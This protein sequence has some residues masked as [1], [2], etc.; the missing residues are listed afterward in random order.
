VRPRAGIAMCVYNGARYLRAQLD[1]FA[2]QSE[3]PHRLVVVDDGSTDG[4]WDLLQAWAARA[5]FPVTLE[6]NTQNLG[7]VRNF[8]KAVRLLLPEVDVVFFSDQD[9]QWY[10]AKLA[11]C[12]DAFVT[13]PRLGL[14]HSDAD[15]VDM[16]GRPLGSRLLAALLVTERERADVASGHAYRAY[17]RRNLVT[18]AAAA[19]RSSVLAQALPFSDQMIH[20]EWISYVAS[21][22]G[23]VRMLEEPLMA[24]RLH[25]ANTVGLPIPNRI[26]W[27]RSVFKALLEPQVPRQ[28]QRLARLQAM[29]AHAVQLGA[30]ADVFA[31]LDRA[32]AHAQHRCSL[33][34]NPLR[35]ALAVRAEWRDGQYRRWSSGRMS[36]LHDLLIAN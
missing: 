32:I 24:Y 5:P 15:L 7:V 36:M 1:S 8:E 13:D 33:S 11:T 17:I 23:P 3:L 30:D 14:V 21:V 28:Q 19:C 35:R 20:D 26:W 9:D 2:S 25:G 29:R 16:E 34:R 4:S 10:P 31:C 6:R 22:V 12:I 18:G 27:W